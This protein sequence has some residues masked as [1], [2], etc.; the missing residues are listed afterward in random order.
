MSVISYS[1]DNTKNEIGGREAEL[2]IT[3]TPDNNISIQNEV[4]GFEDTDGLKVGLDDNHNFIL[5]NLEN[6][7]IVFATN[8]S[9][10][11]RIKNDGS[12]GIGTNNP[13]KKLDVNG[14]IKSDEIDLI[15]KKILLNGQ[16]GDN[17]QVMKVNG[18]ILEWDTIS[19]SGGSGG[20]SLWTSNSNNDIYYNTG[21]IG[22]GTT[23]PTAQLHLSA[24]TSGDCVLRIHA[25]IDNNDEGDVPFIVFTQDG[26]YDVTGIYTEGN[27]VGGSNALVIAHSV[28]NGG[29]KFKTGE[30]NGYRSPQGTLNA[31]D[32]MII[33]KTGKVGINTMT[34]T[35][36]L[37]VN[38]SIKSKDIY[39][40]DSKIYLNNQ[41]GSGGQVI[42]ATSSGLLQYGNVSGSNIDGDIII[43]KSS[44]TS[45]IGP[46]LNLIKYNNNSV[47]QTELELKCY[48]GGAFKLFNKLNDTTYLEYY[49]GKLEIKTREGPNSSST[50]NEG[51]R[52]RNY[53]T[54]GNQYTRATFY[55]NY[56]TQKFDFECLG[57]IIAIAFNT[58][59]DKR[60]KQNIEKEEINNIYEK[61]KNLN[62]YKYNYTEKWLN[63]TNAAENKFVNG[64]LADE[65][66]KVYPDIINKNDLYNNNIDDEKEPELLYKNLKK[67]NTGK[68]LIK[69]LGVI[70]VLQNKVEKLEKELK[71][72]K[73]T[74]EI[75]SADNNH[76][77]KR[78]SHIER[79]VDSLIE[80]LFEKGIIDEN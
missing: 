1:V 42:T 66:D 44:N 68:L 38:G 16:F 15:N 25:D 32:R 51:F 40:S 49:N 57:D 71:N 35:K 29:I 2:Y 17:G 60:I 63:Y 37:E 23:N 21:N 20:S 22:I 28:S 43:S 11:M 34:P 5:S 19:S 62:I 59:S 8:N 53:D 4:T 14:T 69:S 75:L 73:N 30:N 48:D 18:G 31:A 33:D 77:S 52:F 54:N 72:I 56:G 39:L 61:F 10:K 79:V 27:D 26:E 58:T 6:K 47:K 7:G 3:N 24:G 36:T 76:L 50:N 70:K 12:I 78:C 64:L 45:T 67:I 65:V 55:K 41:F 46:Q 80:Q 9:E 13:I 74:N